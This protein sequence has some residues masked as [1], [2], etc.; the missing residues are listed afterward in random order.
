M[1]PKPAGSNTL[2]L[3]ILGLLAA[4]GIFQW[5][6][7]IL[8]ILMTWG[9][10]IGLGILRLGRQRPGDLG[11]QAAGIL[12]GLG[13]GVLYWLLLQA[14][15]LAVA[16]WNGKTTQFDP[17]LAV[18]AWMA[19]AG[20]LLDQLIFFA[21]AEEVVHRGFLFPQIYLRLR[22]RISKPLALS[23]AA[24][25]GSAFFA[26]LHIPHRLKEGIT[27]ESLGFSMLLL[28]LSG[29]FFCG[30]YLLTGNLVTTILVHA[31]SNFPTLPYDAELPWQHLLAVKYGLALGLAAAYAFWFG[32]GKGPHMDLST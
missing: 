8:S 15:V 9:V 22:E 23:G 24:L 12:P 21:S 11:L 14:A 17:Q 29:F 16:H 27:G 18:G 31:L 32:G 5:Q 3:V 30:V 13:F 4:A 6:P 10:V 26:V 1:Y 2:A 7:G 25:L 19:F 20:P 28:V